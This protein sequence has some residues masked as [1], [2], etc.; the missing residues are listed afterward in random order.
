MCVGYMQKDTA[1]PI[2]GLSIPLGLWD[3]F[4]IDTEKLTMMYFFVLRILFT[5]LY[6]I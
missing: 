1:I 2:R 3:R 6:T 5:L 4:V